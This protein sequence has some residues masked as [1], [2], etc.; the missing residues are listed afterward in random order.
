MKA[1]ILNNRVVDIKET[2]FPVPSTMFW[3]DCPVDIKI[4]YKY[5]GTNFISNQPTTE[6]IEEYEQKKLLK[7]QRKQS[8]IAKLKAIGLTDEEINSLLR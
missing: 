3:I 5:D 2:E 8:A 7:E 1:L 4:G 6:Q